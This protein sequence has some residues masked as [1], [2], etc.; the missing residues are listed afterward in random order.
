MAMTRRPSCRCAISITL[1]FCEGDMRT[2]AEASATARSYRKSPFSSLVMSER[3]RASEAP[4]TIRRSILELKDVLLA[5]SMAAYMVWVS[6]YTLMPVR[7]T[8]A[9]LLGP[10]SS[11]GLVA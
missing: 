3:M 1:V 8:S 9:E 5:W 4:F 7:W 6:S 2:K 11:K 10:S